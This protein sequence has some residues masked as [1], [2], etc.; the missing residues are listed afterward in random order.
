MSFLG[1]ETLIAARSFFLLFPDNKVYLNSLSAFSLL[2]SS[3]LLLEWRIYCFVLPCCLS[4][5]MLKPPSATEEC[6]RV[7]VRYLI[8]LYSFLFLLI[9]DPAVLTSRLSMII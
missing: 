2:S 9:I 1:R 3:H 5:L 4:A 6:M 8:K 7:F